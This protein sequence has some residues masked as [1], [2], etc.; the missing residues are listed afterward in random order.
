MKH[1]GLLVSLFLACGSPAPLVDSGLSNDAGAGDAG[2]VMDAS[3]EDAARSDSGPGTDAAIGVD[4][5]EPPVPPPG[6]PQVSAAGGYIR[7]LR[8]A[9]IER[10]LGIPYG[11]SPAGEQR[12][13]PPVARTLDGIYEATDEGSG[14][15]RGGSRGGGVIGEEDCLRLSVWRPEGDGG[16]PKPVMVFFHG[17]AF[18][19][20]FYG[21]AT[22]QGT[23]LVQRGDVLLVNVDYRIGMLGWLATDALAAEGGTAGNYG[24]QDQLLALTWIQDHIAAFGGDP[25]NVTIFGESAGGM[26][27]CALLAT[28]SADGLFHRAVQQSAVGCHFPTPAEYHPVGDALAEAAGCPGGDLACLRAASL[29]S[30][31][32]AASTVTGGLMGGPRLRPVSDEVLL[33]RRRLDAPAGIDVPLLV[34]SNL[35]E[36]DGFVPQRAPSVTDEASY[37]AYLTSQFEEYFGAPQP[38]LVDDILRLYPVAEGMAERRWTAAQDALANFWT[39]T[40]FR[41]PATDTAMIHATA[42]SPTYLYEFRRRLRVGFSRPIAAHGYEL[43]YVFGNFPESVT[44]TDADLALAEQMQD[45][46][47][48]FARTGRIEDA[49]AFDIDRPRRLVFDAGVSSDD[50]T[51]TIDACAALQATGMPLGS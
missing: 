51:A 31:V 47:L 28:P 1:L 41:C 45:V 35:D 49:L 4:A 40:G 38:E 12:F 25:D 30:L 2:P 19:Q 39:D 43:F 37:R 48:E 29:E 21:D 5:P 20:G 18:V 42:G 16:P 24:L 50:A 13:R 27:V 33:D 32:D 15:P 14:C 23:T 8:E 36:G 3:N 6:T 44:P 26:S 7:G 11:E 10:F 46:W 9:G 17:G 22:Y 34:G